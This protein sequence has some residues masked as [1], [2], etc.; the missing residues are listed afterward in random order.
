[1]RKEAWIK[2]KVKKGFSISTKEEK[3]RPNIWERNDKTTTHKATKPQTNQ[4]KKE[5]EKEKEIKI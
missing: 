3:E 5:R 4:Q 1:M 2:L